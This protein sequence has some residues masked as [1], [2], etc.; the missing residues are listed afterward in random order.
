MATYNDIINSSSLVLVEFYANWCPHC[1]RMMPVVEEVKVELNRRCNVFQFDIDENRSLREENNVESIPTFILYK[2]GEE[3]WRKS[4][5]MT[6]RQLLGLI[7][8]NM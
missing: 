1:Q 4:G 7:E 3:I 5:E 6:L 2:Y 8:E